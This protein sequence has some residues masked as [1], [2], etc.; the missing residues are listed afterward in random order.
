MGRRGSTCVW[1]TVV[2][3]T[4]GLASGAM[5]APPTPAEVGEVIVTGSRLPAAGAAI[6]ASPVEIVPRS[7]FNLSSGATLEQTLNLSPQL[8]PTFTSTSNNPG[9]GAATLDL[10]GLGSF[11]TLVLVDGRRWIANSAGSI[12]EVDANTIPSALIQRVDILT[13]GASATYGSDAVSGVIN[14]VLD[15]SFSGLSLEAQRS[16]SERGDAGVDHADLT[17]GG[18]WLDGRAHVIVSTG[19]LER[20]A[21]LRSARRL[22]A[23]ALQDGCGVPGTRTR[24]GYAE[25]A[26]DSDEDCADANET[27]AMIRGGTAAIPGGMIGGPAFFPV[28]AAGRLQRNRDGL[29][30]LPSGDPAPYNPSTDAYNFA[31]D[32]FLQTP[33]R[34][35]NAHLLS[36]VELG[37]LTA[38]ADVAF[39]RTRSDQQLASPPAMLGGVI[40]PVTVN[41]DNPFLT[42]ATRAVLDLNYGV[43]SNGAVGVAD[44][45]AAEPTINPAYLGDAD[46]IVSLGSRVLRRRLIE[47]GP[48]TLENRRDAGLATVGLRGPLG[49][50][51][52]FDA[53]GSHSE[54]RRDARLING[55]LAPRLQ[56]AIVV[57]R[58]ATGQVRC[59]DPSN[60]CRPANIFGEG[61]LDPEV[62]AF[63]RAD[64]GAETTV[65]QTVFEVTASGRLLPLPAGD[66]ELAAGLAWRR[67]S[68]RFDPDPILYD[69]GFIGFTSFGPP[70]G[71]AVEVAEGFAEA[72]VPLLADRPWARDLTLE[73]GARLSDYRGLTRALSW[74]AQ[75]RWSPVSNVSLRASYQRAIRAPNVVELFEAPNM[76]TL[77]AD[78]DPCSVEQGI[79]FLPAVAA[80]C[81]RNGVP[82]ARIARFNPGP[83]NASLVTRGSRDLR[84][85]IAETVTA[86]VVLTRQG[87]LSG[88]FSIDLY[89]IRLQRAISTFG[90]GPLF[91]AYGCIL[92]GGDPNDP[93]CRAYVR[94][95]DGI[96]VAFDLPRA[97][98][99]AISSR[100]VDWQLALARS[101]DAGA[102]GPLRVSLSASGTYYLK[103]G[104]RPNAHFPSIDCAGSFG[105]DCGVTLRG[106]VPRWKL[107]NRL[108]VSRGALSLEIRHS[109]FSSTRD[110]VF[111][112][113]K[114]LG[115]VTPPDARPPEAERLEARHYLDAA[116]AWQVS[117]GL[118]LRFGVN[119]LTDAKPAIAGSSAIQSN[120]D[121][122]LYDVIGRR[123]F[124]T[125]QVRA[126]DA[127][128]WLH[129]R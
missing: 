107:L 73:L 1:A 40:R 91:T 117:P 43:D 122:A 71:A 17:I 68:Y 123:Y 127:A 24:Y 6:S 33:L 18:A 57:V 11:R 34:R 21:V 105:P 118:R 5:A 54:A 59:S 51:W 86:G 48:R 85:E 70:V 103:H 75:G 63:L 19:Y 95:R 10:R 31:D 110:S 66:V 36:T 114:A 64:A 26:P 67:T 38:Y 89:D 8:I 3:A 14:I 28:D 87:T 37:R 88:A 16:I 55:V 101:F 22:S 49:D 106:S 32:T 53:Y 128:R 44:R 58:D 29:R 83:L 27:P 79:G 47:F 65:R 81:V 41:L 23:F 109:Y 121:P 72:R 80:A 104:A 111:V 15:H 129:A 61:Q 77:G 56:Q 116:A 113:D 35:W 42:R 102:I 52:R 93:L 30:F 20:E 124:L 92:G 97:N 94:D 69:G 76:G 126:E 7:A 99:G 2:A 90:G 60:G 62:A 120:T 9:S 112:V 108:E 50:D 39:I 98:I 125:V 96:I 74:K 82:A 100:G 25:A 84:S 4:V 45:N 13:G 119:N 46:G 12:P 78:L 115:L